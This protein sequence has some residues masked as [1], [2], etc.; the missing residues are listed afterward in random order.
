MFEQYDGLGFT[1]TD[2]KGR[3]IRLDC[4]RH[5]G[6]VFE[7]YVNGALVLASCTEPVLDMSELLS[8]NIVLSWL[9][10][11]AVSLLSLYDKGR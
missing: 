4:R 2:D 1:M 9:R 5:D 3:H 11:V 6:C 10:G 8:L 7:L